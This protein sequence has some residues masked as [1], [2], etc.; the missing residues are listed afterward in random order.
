MP[1]PEI[2]IPREATIVV[3]ASDSVTLSGDY[4]CDGVA[5]DVEINAALVLAAGGSVILLDGTYNCIANLAVP[6]DTK[7]EGQGWGTIL[8][9]DDGGAGTVTD[10]GAIDVDGANVHIM[11]LKAQLAAGC[12]AGG[13]RPNV[14]VVDGAQALIDSVWIIG[15]E[16]VADDGSDLRQLGIYLLAGHYTKVTNCIIQ[17]NKKHGLGGSS[18]PNQCIISHNVFLSN[19]QYGLYLYRPDGWIVSNNSL[20]QNFTYGI[21][22]TSTGLNSVI[23]GNECSDSL[24]GIRIDGGHSFSIVGNNC[25]SNTHHGIAITV[26]DCTITG[27]TCDENSRDG[28]YV[29]GENN[30]ITGNTCNRNDFEGNTYMG[31]YISGDNCVVTGNQCTENGL[32]GIYIFR[33]SNCAI[34]G[35]GCFNQYTGDGINITGD[36]TTNSDYNIVTGNNCYSNASHGIEIAGG[37]NAN[38]NRVINNK[39][40]GN[41]TAPFADAGTNTMLAVYVVP[42]VNGNDPSVAGYLVDGGGDLAYTFLRLP[43]EVQQVVRMKVYARTHT[44]ETHEM[45]LEMAVFGGA[46]NEPHNTHDGSIAQLDSVTVNFADNDIIHWVNT[47]AGTLAL[48][49]G[50]SVQVECRH[51]AAEGDNCA[52][53]A[54]FRTVEIE[55]V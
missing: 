37:A 20:R 4:V 50:D 45:E 40:T 43:D 7:L 19:A 30:V 34:S 52:T 47:E 3:A 17:D 26:S 15:D 28:I 11:N 24:T 36:G 46:D 41:V 32:H 6:A 27:N 51:E 12:G 44:A 9:F 33:S 8:N 18:G 54:Y 13:S 49:G 22:I 1:I 39:L 14:I 23:E 35:N 29:T 16:T 42:I 2:H 48:I 53:N 25:F 21:Y 5:D 10:A 55:Y 38:E 31:I